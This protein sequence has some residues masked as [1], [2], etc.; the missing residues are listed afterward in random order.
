VKPALHSEP[1]DAIQQLRDE[2]KQLREDVKEREPSLIGALRTLVSDVREFQQGGRDFPKAAVLGALFAYLR[3][4]I[5]LL[6][7]SLAAVVFAGAQLWILYAQT[8]VMRE[9]TKLFGKQTELSEAQTDLLTDEKTLLRA[10]T[11]AALL[12]G[13]GKGEISARD[14]ALLT[15]FG[16][17]GFESLEILAAGD[18]QTADSVR[19]VLISI[20]PR[21]T[22]PEATRALQILV[23][24]DADALLAPFDM[25]ILE[26]NRERPNMVPHGVINTS[27]TVESYLMEDRFRL[28]DELAM[29]AMN[30]IINADDDLAVRFADAR[31]HPTLIDDFRSIG[32]GKRAALLRAFAR[33]YTA[34]AVT[35]STPFDLQAEVHAVVKLDSMMQ[36]QCHARSDYSPNISAQLATDL[37]TVADHK[38]SVRLDR[39]ILVSIFRW[40]MGIKPPTAEHDVAYE[41][42]K[43]ITEIL[44]PARN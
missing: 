1:T 31:Q 17:I 30:E 8:D 19:R 12:N 29:Q 37:R 4:R 26:L 13:I 41:D 43:L 28:V 23:A 35:S 15:A 16:E 40:C 6:V 24:K 32:L 5:V 11:T 20:A 27:M 39:V 22:P 9:Q 38:A 7:G 14:V 18:D 21:L 36:Y 44:A 33:L 10:Q 42:I 25:K 34:H 3:P 2:I